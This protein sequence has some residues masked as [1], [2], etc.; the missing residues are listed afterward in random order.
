MHEQ[1]RRV[2]GVSCRNP[3]PNQSGADAEPQVTGQ[4]RCVECQRSTPA[5]TEG[6]AVKAD[7]VA[8]VLGSGGEGASS[9]SGGVSQG[10]MHFF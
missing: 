8:R 1:P 5:V 3:N 6:G 10:P 4:T 9:K 7:G 2:F